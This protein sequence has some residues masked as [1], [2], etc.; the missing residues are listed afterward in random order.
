[1][2]AKPSE[3]L[4]TQQPERS[5]LLS[6]F[7]W[8][9]L[10]NGVYAGSQL[11]ILML[12]AKLTRPEVVG[13]YALG[14]AIAV[15]VFWM[16]NL[17]LRLALVSDVHEQTP[18]GHYLSIRL[19]T[20]GL[21]LFT[22]F[23]ITRILRYPWQL[24]AVVLMV[25]VAQAVEAISDMFYARL[26]QHDR[27]SCISKSLMARSALSALGLTLGICLT[28]NLLWGLA[29]IVAARAIVLVGYDT[30][31][32]IQGVA[33]QSK[34]IRR[35]DDLMPRWNP[36]IQFQLLSVNFRLGIL[37]ALVSLNTAL[38]R[39]FIEHALGERT[40][41]IFS[42]IASLR[43]AGDL[44]AFSL[45]VSAFGRFAR[46]HATG[47]LREFRSLLGK[48]LSLGAVLGACG[49]VAAYVAG[50]AIITLVLRPEYAERADLLPWLMV[51]AGG[52]QLALFLGTAMTAAKYYDSQIVLFTLT[53]LCVAALCYVLVPSW[54]LSGA[55]AAMLGG[56]F[57]QLAGS[58]VIL[59]V[60]QRQPA[61]PPAPRRSV[62]NSWSRVGTRSRLNSAL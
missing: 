23:I 16:A 47:N 48:L 13:Q 55:V 37:W 44:A 21:A 30:L 34:R 50:R 51:V 36:R 58:G 8:N 26:Q 20:T 17:Q 52:G 35:N 15:P 38:P 3:V 7:S 39:Y 2:S 11:A 24:S 29:G 33:R 31:E 53:N 1:V 40:L 49:V 41:G 22:I 27:M 61:Y 19:L 6:D 32:R 46:A 4:T 25:G 57:L 59:V 9:L 42:A 28:K 43:A 5:S 60:G 54:G 45:G 14:I 18:F 62:W 12:L 10:G 56:T